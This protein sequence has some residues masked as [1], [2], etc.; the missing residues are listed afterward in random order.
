[1]FQGAE[2][3]ERVPRLP[4]NVLEAVERSVPGS[5]L[6]RL[7][8][9]VER[10]HGGAPTGQVEREGA[11]VGEAIECL[12]SRERQLAR[13]QPVGPLVEEGAGL[14]PGPGRREVAHPGL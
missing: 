13:A 2:D 10:Q 6:E 4:L 9:A 12:S 1:A 3:L 8:A 11:V 14:L 7:G 5:P